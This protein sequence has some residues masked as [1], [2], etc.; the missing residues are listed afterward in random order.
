MASHGA[1]AGRQNTASAQNQLVNQLIRDGQLT[2]RCVQEEGGPREVVG[3]DT[4]DL[5]RDGQPEYQIW[6]RHKPPY[7]EQSIRAGWNTL[8][9]SN[10]SK[11]QISALG[12]SAIAA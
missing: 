6:G 5:N 3:I 9:D 4:L 8:N 10:L 1:Q 11:H 2:M 7:Y 12:I